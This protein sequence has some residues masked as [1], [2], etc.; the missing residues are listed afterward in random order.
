MSDWTSTSSSSSSSSLIQRLLMVYEFF[1]FCFYG[2]YLLVC[3]LELLTKIKSLVPFFGVKIKPLMST[4][5]EMIS[6]KIEL[7]KPEADQFY[8]ITGANSGIGYE[9]AKTLACEFGF[10]VILACRSEERGTEALNKIQQ[11]LN[12]KNSKVILKFLSL[13]LNSL[14]SVKSFAEKIN[15][16]YKVK[17]LIA[18][19]GIMTPPYGLTKEGHETQYGCNYLAHVLLTLLLKNNLAENG[20]DSRIVFVASEAHQTGHVDLE[21]PDFK[22]RPY[23]PFHGY[24]Q[25]KMAQIM[26]TYHFDKLLKK[27]GL[28]GSVSINV[29]HPGIVSTNIGSNIWF[30]FNYVF[31]WGISLVALTPIEGAIN[32]IYVSCAKELE[33]VS[34]KYFCH[35]NLAKSNAESYDP[36]YG[37][38]LYEKTLETL[39]PWL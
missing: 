4:L 33:R 11:E 17:C 3:E 32:Q 14:S 25:S 23:N 7:V 28:G 19:A 35:C 20:P 2:L 39:K 21:D 29:I 36:E 30:P 1:Y 5:E 34:G 26:F 10:N 27:E 22:K 37:T 15:Q 16:Q 38:K 31:N 6:H 18:N 13:D 8:I 12:K 24:T 9:T